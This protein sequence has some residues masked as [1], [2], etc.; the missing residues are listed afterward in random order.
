VS[1]FVI[2]AEYP[3][4]APAVVSEEAVAVGVPL[5]EV[6]KANPMRVAPIRADVD[7][8]KKQLV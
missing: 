1:E 5:F 6:A 4:L 2:H 7:C 8:P 3:H